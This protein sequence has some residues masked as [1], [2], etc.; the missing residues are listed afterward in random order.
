MMQTEAWQSLTPA[1]VRVWIELTSRF[2]GRNNG[3]IALSARDA[4]ARCNIA[5]DTATKSFAELVEKGF[6]ECATPG[7]FTRK[8]RHATEWRLTHLPC[9]QTRQLPSKAYFKWRPAEN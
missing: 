2:N 6:L 8:V 4:A 5:K 3:I 1:S 9:D 7:G